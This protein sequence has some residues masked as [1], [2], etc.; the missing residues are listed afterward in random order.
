MTGVCVLSTSH[1]AIHTWPLRGFFVM[2]VYSCRDFDPALVR[3][4]VAERFGAYQ[5]RI[6]DLTFS[7]APD[8]EE[9]SA[10]TELQA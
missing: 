9:V 7:L 8:F 10:Q 3:Q 2:D 1:C 4:M 6:T 5:L